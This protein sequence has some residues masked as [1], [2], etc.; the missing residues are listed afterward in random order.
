MDFCKATLKLTSFFCITPTS[1]LNTYK[2][3]YWKYLQTTAFLIPLVIFYGW[4]FAGNLGT[5]FVFMNG[6]NVFVSIFC[7]VISAL[8]V[9]VTILRRH[10]NTKNWNKFCDGLNCLDETNRRISEKSKVRSVVWIVVLHVILFGY[11]GIFSYIWSDFEESNIFCYQY[12]RLLNFYYMFLLICFTGSVGNFL[13]GRLE[14]LEK[15]LQVVS[16]PKPGKIYLKLTTPN[17]KDKCLIA[18]IRTATKLYG[19]IVDVIKYFNE[20]YGWQILLVISYNVVNLLENVNT[21]RK[22]ANGLYSVSV[23]I[24]TI[25][26]TAKNLVN[27]I[28]SFI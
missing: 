16:D 7:G 23:T 5:R 8:L 1:H 21:V 10:F 25:C 27:L 20:M 28:T 26:A 18:N 15:I 2:P 22:G 12:Y 13:T 4:S 19:T 11:L 24:M 9:V 14:E 17:I 6:V 3:T